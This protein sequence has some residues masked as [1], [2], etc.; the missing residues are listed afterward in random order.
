LQKE[1]SYLLP[2]IKEVGSRQ[3][4]VKAFF[5]VCDGTMLD[6]WIP[7]RTG[8]LKFKIMAKMTV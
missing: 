3:K 5:A 7:T 4:A 1:V 2:L 8:S 6:P